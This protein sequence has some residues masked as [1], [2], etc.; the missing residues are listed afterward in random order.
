ME[1]ICNRKRDIFDDEDMELFTEEMNAA[2]LK[3]NA[4]ATSIVADMFPEHKV[5]EFEKKQGERE[6]EKL[7]I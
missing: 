5:N 2:R 7:M 3:A 6:L 1:V 4:V